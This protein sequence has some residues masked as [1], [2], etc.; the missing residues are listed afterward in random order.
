M[1]LHRL[2]GQVDEAVE[3]QWRHQEAGLLLLLLLLQPSPKYQES[4]APWLPLLQ[5]LPQHQRE[6]ALGLPGQRFHQ[7]LQVQQRE[8]R[9]LQ[10]P[11]LQTCRLPLVHRTVAEPLQPM[12][13][14]V[15]LASLHYYQEVVLARCL[16]CSSFLVG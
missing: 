6:L 14:E 16:D 10:Q 5:L 7:E 12:A 3:E 15:M 2:V 4:Q 8:V 13:A 1:A 11:L 9:E